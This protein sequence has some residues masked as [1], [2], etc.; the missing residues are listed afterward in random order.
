MIIVHEDR[1]FTDAEFAAIEILWRHHSVNFPLVNGLTDFIEQARSDIYQAIMELREPELLSL[2]EELPKFKK[3]KFNNRKL[4][5]WQKRQRGFMRPALGFSDSRK[6]R[7]IMKRAGF[8]VGKTAEIVKLAE[9]WEDAE[10][11]LH[12]Q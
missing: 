4:L 3:F 10:C 12:L 8:V 11:R 7:K 9:K 1:K 6:S 2:R 5:A